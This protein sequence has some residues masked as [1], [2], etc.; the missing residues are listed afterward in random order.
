VGYTVIFAVN[1]PDATIDVTLELW[2]T[3]NKSRGTITVQLNG[4]DSPAAGAVP[5]AN[6][7]QD[8]RL[9]GVDHS[10]AILDS[11]ALKLLDG[12]VAAVGS[13]A[14]SLNSLSN[15]ISKLGLFVQI[16]DKTAKVNISHR[17]IT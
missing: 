2:M 7:M 3:D 11:T 1:I 14:N 4:V 9:G 8:I 6:A 10:A 13:T 5:I 17:H 16:V 12:G 15:V